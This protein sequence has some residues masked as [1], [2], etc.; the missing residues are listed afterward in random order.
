MEPCLPSSAPR[1]PSGADW[2]HEIKF[3]GYRLF[4][5]RDGA[6]VRLLTRSC[7]DWTDRYPL[8]AKP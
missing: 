2:L 3:D 4:A 1:P 6:A 8:S 5:R 7:Y